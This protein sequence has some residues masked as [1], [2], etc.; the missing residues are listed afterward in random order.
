MTSDGDFGDW[1]LHDGTL[2]A[3]VIDWR[4]RTCRAELS[5]WSQRSSSIELCDIVWSGV[6][7]V[8]VP[9][10]DPW[11][12]SSAINSQYVDA[13]GRF[14]VEMQSGDTIAIEADSAIL[15]WRVAGA[16]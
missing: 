5:N 12:H 6:R 8:D 10:R 11:G 4:A 7:H 16:G 2:R 9:S 3:V 13:N 15:E 14:C 1:P